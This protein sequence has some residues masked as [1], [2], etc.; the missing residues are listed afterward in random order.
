M[1]AGFHYHFHPVYQGLFASGCLY[2]A[3]RAQPLFLW[4]YD[5]G[6]KPDVIPELW[7]TRIMDLSRFARGKKTIE[8]FTLS[9]FDQDH[10]SGVVALLSVFTIDTL[11]LPYV[12]LWQ[13]LEV[14]L[15]KGLEEG[16]EGMKFALDPVGFLRSSG[17]INRVILVKGSGDEP[18]PLSERRIDG[19]PEDWKLY[20]PS[21][22]LNP[23]D[24][25]WSEFGS[26]SSDVEI[27]PAGQSLTVNG[28]WEFCP[29]VRERDDV[30]Q[31]F[32][33]GIK[34]LASE[35]LRAAPDNRKSALAALKSSYDSQLGAKGRARN[36]ISL[37]LYA[38]PVYETWMVCKLLYNHG[39]RLPAYPQRQPCYHRTRA[40][41]PGISLKCSILYS[42]DGYLNTPA[43][44]D[45]LQNYLQPDRLSKLGVFQVN[46]H[47]AR[48]NWHEGL[49]GKLNPHLSVFS[50]NPNSG[51]KHPDAAVLRDY[52]TYN[53]V[54]V[55]DVGHS[56]G[57]W[58][59][60]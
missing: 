21:K 19:P 35:L 22:L 30:P 10:I 17:T 16:S 12:P 27:L 25:L 55:C 13:R 38:G 8:L 52:W 15:A 3:N 26:P 23:K 7:H 36:I 40:V 18:L 2:E 37:F 31:N 56:S 14:A 50:S 58:L 44:W 43:T 11:L 41:A 20:S 39:S 6:C 57:G 54:Q 28:L 4:V 24:P 32:A 45:H 48:G 1:T 33:A 51:N 9:H 29:Y 5:C 46:H 34:A 47:G 49:A 53:P 59:L 42:G 60:L